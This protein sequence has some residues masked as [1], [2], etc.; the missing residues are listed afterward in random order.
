M[1]R[2]TS[3]FTRQRPKC[4]RF[5]TRLQP[6]AVTI[7]LGSRLPVS[8]RLSVA[9]CFEFI[10]FALSLSDRSSLFPM[11]RPCS[12]AG[13]IRTADC[14]RSETLRRLLAGAGIVSSAWGDGGAP[15]RQRHLKP[16]RC[17]AAEPAAALAK[18]QSLGRKRTPGESLALEAAAAAGDLSLQHLRVFRSAFL[19][20]GISVTAV[21]RTRHR[22]KQ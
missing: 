9:G 18:L 8:V 13:D 10:R 21:T 3:F 14:R 7:G 1:A 11:V 4:Y 12:R 16:F 17:P 22:S 19:A 5:L 15:G 2:D 6:F 20:V